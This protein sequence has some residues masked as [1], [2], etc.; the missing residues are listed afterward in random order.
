M[1][2]TFLPLSDEDKKYLRSLSKT[3]TIQAQIVDRARIL[4]YKAD[5]VSFDEIAVRLNISKRTVRLCI[6]K[7]NEGGID[8]ALFDAERSGRPVE[9]SDDAKA[10]ILN[11]ACQRPAEL[12]YSQELWTLTKLHKHIQQNAEQ[13][14]SQ[15]LQR[16][17]NLMCRSS[18]MIMISNLSKLSII[19]KNTI[20][21]LNQKCMMSLL[22]INKWKCSLM[23]TV[24]L[25][26][27]MII[28]LP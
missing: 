8:A 13:A 26:S 25:S 20:L 3:R 1:K 27:R 14:A 21:I 16:L 9:I 4:L 12:G 18:C 11:I 6:S 2:N 5:G 24:I 28:S 10:W 15:G 17:P 22:S 19:A 7:F 23:Q